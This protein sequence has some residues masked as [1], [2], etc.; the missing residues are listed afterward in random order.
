MQEAHD[1]FSHEPNK[2]GDMK[3][4]QAKE[5]CCRFEK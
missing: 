1:L 5:K 3:M 4:G 2:I